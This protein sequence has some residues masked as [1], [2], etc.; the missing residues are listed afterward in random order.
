MNRPR[1]QLFCFDGHTAADAARLADLVG[2][3]VCRAT[4][5]PPASAYPRYDELR[6]RLETAAGGDDGERLEE[7][8]LELYAHVHGFSAPYTCEERRRVDETGGYWCHAGG[9]SPVLR[10]A[11]LLQPDAVS[12]D[13]GAGNGLQLLLAQLL[14]PHRLAIQIE[15]S[16]VMVEQGRELQAWL[17]IDEA[18]VAWRVEDV[19]EA[20]VRGANLVY[21]YRP[22]HASGPGVSFYDRLARE[23]VAATELDHVL[24]IADAMGARLEPHF[25][26]AHTDGHLTHFERVESA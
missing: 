20:S 16:S 1:S 19:M 4:P 11:D 2:C 12:L 17:E 7:A 24:S 5:P 26:V 14:R 8:L 15:I 23:M 3:F 18:R 10:A 21:M 13:L 22:L 6:G 9:L 25:R